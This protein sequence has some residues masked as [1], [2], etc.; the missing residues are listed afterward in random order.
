MSETERNKGTLTPVDPEIVKRKAIERYGDVF[1]DVESQIS[2]LMCDSD[3]M[4]INGVY[5]RCEYE[6]EAETDGCDF[7]DVKMDGNKIHFH[8]MHYNGGGSLEEVLE[9]ALKSKENK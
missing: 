3:F 2:E 4:K 1:D 9:A 7:A 6:V 8:T 5:Y